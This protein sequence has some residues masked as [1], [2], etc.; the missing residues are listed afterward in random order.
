MDRS[1]L[2]I[3][4]AGNPEIAVPTLTALASRFTVVGVLTNPDRPA[5]RGRHLLPPPVKVE[6]QRLGIPVIQF[7][8]L[9]KE[10]REEVSRLD[11]N[12]LLSFACGHYFGPKFLSLFPIG[13]INVHPSQLPRYRG[14][15]PIQFA[16]LNGERSTGITLQR[17]VQEID[18]GDILSFH[19]IELTGT[20]TADELEHRVAPQAASLV[21][22]TVERLLEGTLVETPQ[23]AH[24][25]TYTRMLSKQDGQIDWNSSVRDIH[26]KVRAF[27]PWPK[28][29]TTFEGKMLQITGVYGSV[30]DVPHEILDESV[31]PG[32]V[33]RLDKK[34]GLAVACKDGVL[35]VSR[36]QLAQKKEMD[37]A[38]F[39][40]GNPA[41]IGAVLGQVDEA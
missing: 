30:F 6:A 3:L 8:R 25:A 9:R 11:P 18:S 38:S 37:S 32:T 17:I 5:G 29:S 28:A 40:N 39:C 21:V 31:V 10:A 35:F 16:I 20:E 41:I 14:C 19:P 27:L 4:F 1:Q 26:G 12:M 22:S 36:L 2:R 15:A 33:L 24:D 23:Q 34:R 7:D 13:A